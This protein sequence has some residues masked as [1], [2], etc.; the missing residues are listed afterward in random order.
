MA[1]VSCRTPGLRRPLCSCVLLMIGLVISVWARGDELKSEGAPVARFPVCYDY[2]C[3]TRQQVE[4]YESEFAAVRAM[5]AGS[6]D[7]ADE[8][9]RIAEALGM[10]ERI[11]GARTPTRFDLP[12]NGRD[13]QSRGGQM[14]CVDE[15]TNASIYLRVFQYHGLMQWHRVLGRTNR[16]PLIFN[17]H[18]AAQIEETATSRRFAVDSWFRGNGEP[19]VVQPIEDWLRGVS[20]TGS[21]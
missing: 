13:A 16:A 15:S 1:R 21:G 14:D 12:G 17:I 11:V 4:I 20:T 6:R 2:G 19:A 8:R 9:T 18:Y 7:A 3:A 5:L 10:M